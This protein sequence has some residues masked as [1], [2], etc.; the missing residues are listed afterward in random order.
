MRWKRLKIANIHQGRVSNSLRW[1]K[2]ATLKRLRDPFTFHAGKAS[3]QT[4][5]RSG[6]GWWDGSTAWLCWW[7]HTFVALSNPQNCTPKR[8]NTTICKVYFDHWKQN[9]TGIRPREESG[10]TWI[11]ARRIR[12]CGCNIQIHTDYRVLWRKRDV[13]PL[14][15]EENAS[16]ALTGFYCFSRPL[17]S[18][19]V[20][21]YYA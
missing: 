11:L 12:C 19:M 9:K 8:A 21:I 1:V 13:Q 7:S 4:A 5:H 18:K 2:A 6:A 17:T 14:S 10:V 15:Q 16:L 3:L 20:L